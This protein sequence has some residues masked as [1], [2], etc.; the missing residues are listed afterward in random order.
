MFRSSIIIQPGFCE[1]VETRC[2]LILTNNLELNKK[3]QKNPKHPFVD[4]G[5]WETCGKFQQKLLN[6]LVVGACQSFQCFRQNKWF[7]AKKRG[8][9]KF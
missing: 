2:F 3:K 6:S 7:F 1:C 8:S 9:S 5:K 4:I